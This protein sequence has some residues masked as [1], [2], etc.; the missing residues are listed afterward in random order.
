[1][2]PATCNWFFPASA[3]AF[4]K[5]FYFV[6]FVVPPLR[7]SAQVYSLRSSYP[8]RCSDGIASRRFYPALPPS[9]AHYKQSSVYS[10][11]R[12]SPRRCAMFCFRIFR[13]TSRIHGRDRIRFG[14]VRDGGP[15]TVRHAPSRVAQRRGYRR[16]GRTASPRDVFIPVPLQPVYSLRSTVYGL[17]Y[18]QF[19]NSQVSKGLQSTVYRLQSSSSLIPNPLINQSPG[20]NQSTPFS[21]VTPKPVS[22]TISSLHP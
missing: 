6:C 12:S 18:P 11:L 1:M 16:L 14:S 17:L 13:N 9:R 22:A 21:L 5:F 7:V 4:Q 19:P 2:E 3:R 20:S 8:F 15:I 10:L